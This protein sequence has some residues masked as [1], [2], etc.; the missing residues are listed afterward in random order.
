[1]RIPRPAFG[2]HVAPLLAKELIEIA[3]R[4]RSYLLRVAFACGVFALYAMR[5]HS[6]L[7]AA[8]SGDLAVLGSGRHMLDLGVGALFLAIY[9]LMP[10]MVAPS[11]LAEREGG[12]LEVLLVSRLRP[13]QLL[14]QKLLSR[15]LAMGGYLAL[16]LPL[17]G[18]AYSLGGLG[19]DDLIAAGLAL[20]C[21]TLQV[22]AWSLYCGARARTALSGVVRAYVVG[23]AALFILVPLALVPLNI[24]AALT[25]LDIG[26]SSSYPMG[27]YFGSHD[28]SVWLLLPAC[29]PSL[30]SAAVMF[31]MACRAL[32]YDDRWWSPHAPARS[33]E[34][35]QRTRAVAGDL[36]VER[37]VAWRE[38]ARV[39]RA[40]GG[41]GAWW[42]LGGFAA[43]VIL[44][45]VALAREGKASDDSDGATVVVVVAHLVA[46]AMV[47]AQAAS[48]AS[49][50]RSRGTLEVLL[51][52][53]L[54]PR[55]IVLQ[56]LAGTRRLARIAL[57]ALAVLCLIEALLEI[58]MGPGRAAM[59]LVASLGTAWIYL[60]AAGWLGM[61]IGLRARTPAAAAMTTIALMLGWVVVPYAAVPWLASPASVGWLTLLNPG[62]L[63][64]L[65]EYPQEPLPWLL[66]IA[67]NTLW[68]GAIALGLRWWCLLDAPRRLRSAS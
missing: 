6:Q 3:A 2:A 33:S 50:E 8:E 16:A 59:Y 17:A 64:M 51:A 25:G 31:L 30:A 61:A 56:K 24:V 21:G 67:V 57:G 35:L 27:I 44:A 32:E 38:L 60:E 11:V 41:N 62:S 55:D 54:E 1:M 18:I 34:L 13:W 53:P 26:W 12:T 40:L 10:A 65:D 45:L 28:R 14:A 23:V 19:A 42:W 5:F 52:T 63:V 29:I 46:L 15:T 39:R 49:E 36:P 37:P 7:A 47:A 22:G 4:P 58:G 68:Y 20:A 48:L 43:L 9:L 66:A